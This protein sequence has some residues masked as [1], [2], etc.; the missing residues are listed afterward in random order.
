MCLTVQPDVWVGYFIL[1]LMVGTRRHCEIYIC[2]PVMTPD[3]LIQ[4]IFSEVGRPTP[5]GHGLLDEHSTMLNE[6]N[7]YRLESEYDRSEG[8]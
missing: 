8:R 4:M 3:I 1:Y 2:I 6:D 5:A 7:S